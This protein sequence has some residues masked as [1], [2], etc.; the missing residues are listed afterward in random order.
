MGRA[1][2]SLFVI[3]VT[4]ISLTSTGCQ[5]GIYDDNKKLRDQNRELQAQ[6]DEA[7]RTPPA[8]AQTP[9]SPVVSVAPGQPAAPVAAPVTPAPKSK[10]DFGGLDARVDD[11]AGT[12]TVS[13]PSDVFFGSGQATILPEAKKSLDKVVT[14]L[15][16]EYAGKAVRIEG[17]TDSDPI[18]HSHWKSNQELSEK[19]AGAVHDYLVSKGIDASRVT[20]VGLGDTK[21]KSQTD[22]KKNR[23]VELVV[24]TR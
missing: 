17:H 20:T 12:T 6:L 11:N 10:P 24:I 5:N 16:K 9:A 15:K 4:A 23:R 1:W 21:P 18:V 13:L 22:K 3:A 19:R 8:G 2:N 7:H 14:V